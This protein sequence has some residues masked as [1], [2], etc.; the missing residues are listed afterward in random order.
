MRAWK[1]P[2]RAHVEAT[3]LF[4]LK[5]SARALA[6]LSIASFVVNALMWSV[7]ALERTAPGDFHVEPAIRN[8]GDLEPG[9]VVPVVFKATNRSSRPV[10]VLGV[11]GGCGIGGC[12]RAKSLPCV[13]AAHGG[14]D[15]EISFSTTN[16]PPETG[17]AFE[18]E[19]A[20]Y[21]DWPGKHAILVR[22]AGK[23]VPADAER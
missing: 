5:Y 6:I 13:V 8:L 2:L 15:I 17:V 12:V 7:S 9:L 4:I 21:T 11:S 22:V 3:M 23:V 19:F 16:R 18:R 1:R 10:R 14:A 20:L